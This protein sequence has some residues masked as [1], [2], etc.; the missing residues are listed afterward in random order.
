M[1][2]LQSLIVGIL[3]IIVVLLVGVHQLEKSTGMS[4]AKVVNIYNWG[5]YIDPDLLTKFEKESGYKVNYDTFDS[6]EAMFTKIQQ[7]GTSY[8]IAIPSE[9]MIEKMMDEKLLIQLDHQKIKGLDNIDSR[10]LDLSF[11]P[12]N[13][14]SIPYFWGTLGIIYN[15]KFV[16]AE[17][18]TSWD[19]LWRPE[20]KNNLMLIDG[21]REVIGLGL[22]SLGYSLNSTNQTELD[23]AVKKLRTMMPN[24]KAVVA[25]EI[26]MYMANEES[27]VAVTFSGEAADMMWENEHLHYVIPK[28]GSNL[29]FDN[30][31]IPK[32]AANVD[33]AYDF[34]NFMLRPE[35]A[36]QNAEYIGYST[37]NK[38]ALDL[39]PDEITQDKQFY[40]S[41]DLMSHLE[42]YKNLGPDYLGIYNDL[43]LEL[44][45]Y[46]N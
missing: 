39:L 17:E 33:G 29:W 41:D 14:Y 37:P 22:N 43:F 4:G 13:Q 28:E 19:D 40:P 46:R 32:T 20:L 44:K 15:D 5:D 7:G 10:F 45:M 18:M 3:A 36:A 16:K 6:N 23:E 25:D 11:D 27:A 34:I 30:I 38:K 9:Y 26:K 42:V 24:V 8:D 35:N 12:K 1:R 2:R 31:V 21:A